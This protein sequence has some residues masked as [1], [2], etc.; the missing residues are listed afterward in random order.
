MPRVEQGAASV[1]PTPIWIEQL[2][3]GRRQLHHPELVARRVGDRQG[4]D[5]DAAPHGGP[6]SGV[7]KPI[8]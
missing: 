3:P 5:F 2:E 7:V 4:H 6:P 1:R 8:M